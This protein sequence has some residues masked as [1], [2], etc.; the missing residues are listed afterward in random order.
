[1]NRR[2]ETMTGSI[3]SG[4]LYTA[5]EARRRLGLGEWARRQFRRASW[6]VLRTGNSVFVLGDDLIEFLGTHSNEAQTTDT[7]AKCVA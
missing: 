4:Y 5:Q 1:M 2:T 3:A 7:D 6:K